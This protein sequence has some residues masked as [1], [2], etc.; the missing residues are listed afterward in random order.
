MTRHRDKHTSPERH[1]ARHPCR[2]GFVPFGSGARIQASNRS[3]QMREYFSA[4]AISARS[5]PYRARTQRLRPC[6]RRR[7]H[8]RFG[9]RARNQEIQHHYLSQ[10]RLRQARH[11]LL[12]RTLRDSDLCKVRLRRRRPADISDDFRRSSPRQAAPDRRGQRI[13][14][15]LPGHQGS[16]APFPASIA[17]PADG[18]G[19]VGAL[20]RRACA[21]AGVASRFRRAS[22]SS[23]CWRPITSISPS[24]AA[25]GCV[26]L[27]KRG[28]WREGPITATA[29]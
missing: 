10:A 5:R 1:A 18:C 9:V 11:F 28:C 21:L 19:Y 4:K 24:R 14:R 23:K 8:R 3:F 22:P 2:H 27:A 13:A 6:S 29:C 17:A 20:H 15:V 7:E 26:R 25:K 16:S 12:E